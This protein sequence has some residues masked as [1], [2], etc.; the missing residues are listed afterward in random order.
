MITGRE[1]NN[2][3]ILINTHS[4]SL[5]HAHI[6]TVYRLVYVSTELVLKNQKTMFVP[7]YVALTSV[8]SIAPSCK[9]F[10]TPTLNIL[11]NVLQTYLIFSI[12]LMLVSI[13]K[14]VKSSSQM[15]STTDIKKGSQ[16]Q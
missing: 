10:D 2:S 15:W 6:H 14:T 3:L 9:A 12:S 4:Y 13:L 5:T 11:W 8:T 1:R 16:Y 7:S